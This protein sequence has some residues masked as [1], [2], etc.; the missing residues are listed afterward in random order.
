MSIEI[1]F[2]LS[3]YRAGIIFSHCQKILKIEEPICLSSAWGFH[4][5]SYHF[6]VMSVLQIQQ[7]LYYKVI[8][9]FQLMEYTECDSCRSVPPKNLK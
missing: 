9:Q 6:E 2:N 8:E 7:N 3:F 4:Y 1:I 5:I